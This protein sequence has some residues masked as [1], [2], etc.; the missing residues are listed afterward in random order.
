MLPVHPLADVFPLMAG[1]ALA[2]LTDDVALNGLRHPVTLLDGAVLDGRSRL[3]ACR[4]AS[5]QPRFVNFTGKDPPPFLMVV[6]VWR[7]C[8]DLRGGRLAP[9][10]VYIQAMRTEFGRPSS[11]MRLGT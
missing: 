11:S 2:D 1:A 4:T 6:N 9:N 5:V 10:S 7:C 3:A 8:I